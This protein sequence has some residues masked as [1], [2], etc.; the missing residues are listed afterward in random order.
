MPIRRQLLS[1]RNVVFFPNS[2]CWMTPPVRVK[3]KRC[4]VSHIPDTRTSGLY[5]SVACILIMH[6]WPSGVLRS[7]YLSPRLGIV[8]PLRDVGNWGTGAP[9]VPT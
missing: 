6:R 4:P 1:R 5:M 2:P 7:T 8:V 3:S 9:H